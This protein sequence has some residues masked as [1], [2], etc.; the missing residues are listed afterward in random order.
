MADTNDPVISINEGKIRGFK[1]TNY[2]G[3]TIYEFLGIPFA[4]PPVNELRFKPPEPIEP[5]T[6]VR[7]ATKP[8]S[9]SI[10][11]DDLTRELVG[12]EDCLSVNVYTK[13][14]PKHTVTLKP[15]MVYIYGGG[16]TSGSSRPG[17]YGPEFLLLQDIVL[18]TFNYRLGVLGFL[19]L[20]DASLGVPGNNGF[21]DQCM[22]L[23]WVQKNIKNF[24]GD[25]N[26]VTIFGESAGSASVHAHV[27]SPASRGLFHRAIL[28]SGCCL[29]SW[30]WGSKDNARNLVKLLGK[31]AK[32]DKEALEILKAAPA[33]D[34]FN[35][36]EKMGDVLFPAKNRPFS[37]V[38]ESPNPDGFLTK[39]PVDIMKEGSYNQVSLVFGYTDTEGMLFDLDKMLRR[40]SG[41][42]VPEFKI[43]KLIP[44]QINVPETETQTICDKLEKLYKNERN[45]SRYDE[46]T[47]SCF[48]IGIIESL[49]MHLATAQHPIYLYR[50]SICTELNHLKRLMNKIN[51]PGVCHADDLGYLF[52]TEIT[53]D[54]QKNSL[55][56]RS[57]KS[58]VRLWTNFAKFGNP[59]VGD[60]L[61]ITW[62]SLRNGSS[63]KLL[64]IGE[65]LVFKDIP[66]SERLDVWK[67]IL[68]KFPFV[69]F[70]YV[71][72]N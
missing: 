46:A 16:L 56:E 10:S 28:Q 53:P 1:G 44:Y 55:E 49:K 26:N 15:V 21:K 68:N 59:T 60:D 11:R 8:G 27:L 36:Q 24:S 51:D 38:I 66:E 4:K 6:D 5:W 72:Q 12:N 57:M 65:K 54:I 34:I 9:P 61:Q 62:E 48:L 47:D 20:S 67:Q 17:L 33:L 52:H 39:S 40:Q 32:N 37:A 35:A 45:A 2:D 71:N 13:Y 22:A 50:V 70:G 29:N 69:R 42:P 18:V 19:S 63:L 23:K 31:D 64:D 3:E 25:P 41:I 14:L 58:F 7:D 30:F 43:E